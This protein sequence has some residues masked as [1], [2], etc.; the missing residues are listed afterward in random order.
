MTEW[1]GG[2][3]VRVPLNEVSI[4]CSGR[5]LLRLCL[6]LLDVLM[7]LMTLPFSVLVALWAK[8]P[9]IDLDLGFVLCVVGRMF[10]LPI[11]ATVVV[12]FLDCGTSRVLAIMLCD[13]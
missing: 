9:A 11:E 6:L 2:N 12:C 4:G 13:A 7:D 5:G 1:W 10:S 8:R 3:C